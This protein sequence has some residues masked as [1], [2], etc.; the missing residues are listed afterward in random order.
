MSASIKTG[1]SSIF[2]NFNGLRI[3]YLSKRNNHQFK[4]K[5]I[6]KIAIFSIK[7]NY[8]ATLRGINAQNGEITKINKNV[9]NLK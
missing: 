1:F 3:D 6:I 8:F 2:K 4:I 9:T 5:S 7:K